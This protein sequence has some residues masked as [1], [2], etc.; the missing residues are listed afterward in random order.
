[1][2]VVAGG[3][4]R[5]FD[6]VVLC[7]GAW[8]SAL[9]PLATM[10]GRITPIRGQLVRLA[11]RQLQLTHPIWGGSCYIVPW[12]DGTVLVGATSE[13]AGFDERATVD[14]V[15]QLLASAQDLVPA[16]ASAGFEGVRVG[17]RPGT[18]D[19]LPIL[20]PSRDPRILYAA[21]HFRNGIL[22]APLTARLIA[23]YVFAGAVD[24]AFS[25]A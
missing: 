14:G 6:R 16:L 24:P 7:A 22:L 5:T 19:G 3:E 21:G 4:S 15:R 8:T 2:K 9:D 11:A 1:V 20:G 17:L 25:A 10:A 18:A 23:N 12:A 13:D